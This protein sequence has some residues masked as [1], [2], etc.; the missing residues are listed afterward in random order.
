MW[1]WM[2][3]RIKPFAF[4]HVYVVFNNSDDTLFKVPDMQKWKKNIHK[5]KV[6]KSKEKE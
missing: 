1:Y 6:G 5:N 4:M 2:W 3:V